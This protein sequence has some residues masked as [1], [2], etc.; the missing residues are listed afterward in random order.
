[1]NIHYDDKGKFFTDVITKDALIVVIRTPIHQIHGE[2]YVRQGERLID[3]L[4]QGDDFIAVTNARIHNSRGESL[5]QTDFLTV[6]RNQIMWMIPENEMKPEK[7]S[8][9]ANQ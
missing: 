3:E 8:Q 6:N 7:E 4:N 5:Y 2:V 1:M 9:G